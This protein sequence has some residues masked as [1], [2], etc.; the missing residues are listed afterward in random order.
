[1]ISYEP[2]V[3]PYCSCG[4]GINLVIK[5]GKII[6]QE[7]WH[8]HPINAGGNCPK[9]RNAYQ[10]LYADDRLTVPMIRKNGK[11]T[12]V[13]WKEALD[14]IAD[15]LK[16]AAP[17]E[18]GLLASGKNTNEDAYVLQ[19]FARAVMK[20][21]NVEYCGRLCHSSTAAGLGATVG[22]GV[23]PISQLDL[24]KADCFLLVG[25]NPSETFPMMARRMFKAKKKGAKV[26]VI[27][28]RHTVTAREL[29]NLHLQL[30]S[31]TDVAVINA[32][33]K[34]ILEGGLE[35][36]KFIESRTTGIDELRSHLSAL[37]LK[38]MT[39]ITGV[40]EKDLKTAAEWFAKAKTGS[41]IYN[42]GL[43]QHTTGAD[44]IKA[45]AS[46]A[47]ITG[48]Y[49]R[50]GTGL[51]PTRGQI[52]GEGTGDMGCLNVFYPGFQRVG[53]DV[54]ERFGKLWGVDNLPSEPGLPYTK[55]IQ[56]TKY[57]WIVGTNPM[58]AAPDVE[59][60]RKSLEEKELL[61]VQDIFPTETAQLADVILPAT[62]WVE[63]EGIHAYV[64]RRVQKIN[65]IIA[66]PGKAKHDWWIVVQVAE[67]MGYKDK[68]DFSS[69]GEILEEIRRCV[70]PYKGITYER[71]ENAVGGI[72][73][74]CPSEDHPGTSTFFT[75]KFNTP[76]GLGHL[77]VVEFKPPAELPD[78]EYP[79]ILTTGRSIFHYHTGTMSRRTPKLDA[80]ISDGYVEIN[81]KDAITKGVREGTVVTLRTRRGAVEVRAHLTNDVPQGLVFL[82][83][84][85]SES[86][87]NIMTN[88]VLDPA[89]GMPE[90][91]VCAVSVEVSQ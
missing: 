45:L 16:A 1:M 56:Q 22:S 30:A 7:P 58:M 80:E 63:R 24:E 69:P 64:D 59:N 55:M 25:V 76:D 2:T 71:L 44:G 79:F 47:L 51:C 53:G 40:S 26:I 39:K 18:F 13:S 74:P 27:D 5:D 60:V 41:V 86:C 49:G 21:N 23:M 35:N 14:F 34:I 54:H 48:Q 67:R 38:E 83:F 90:Y 52:N 88:P 32:M 50:P 33:M 37:D 29:G 11:L 15:K 10:F 28:P 20:T 9:G 6:G 70:P 77:Q 61:V 91:K 31:G 78:D 85:F 8:E 65:P 73:W 17:G 19:K 84:H 75:E 68:F 66:P 46:L 72:Q 87:A 82:P 3:C 42:Q 57:L 81:P 12:E 36:T 62:T 43:N 4:C 89:C